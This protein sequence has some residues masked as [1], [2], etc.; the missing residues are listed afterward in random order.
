VAGLVGGGE[1]GGM[2]GLQARERKAEG[3][4]YAVASCR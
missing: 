3:E 4:V 2:G 1:F